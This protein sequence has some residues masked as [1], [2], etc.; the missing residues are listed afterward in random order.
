MDAGEMEMLI[1]NLREMAIKGPRE[2][3]PQHW[4]DVLDR[5]RALLGEYVP[6]Q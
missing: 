1:W 3:D 6:V 4:N 2:I 5:C